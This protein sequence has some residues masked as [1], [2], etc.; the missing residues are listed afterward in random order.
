MTIEQGRKNGEQSSKKLFPVAHVDTSKLK[1]R[2]DD[3]PANLIQSHSE[4]QWQ[5][6]AHST[7][8]LAKDF[9]KFS[10]LLDAKI[11]AK[12]GGP[13]I[14]ESS[15]GQESDEEDVDDEGADEMSE[16]DEEEDGS[17]GEMEDEEEEA[18]LFNM[19]EADLENLDEQLKALDS[20]VDEDA[21]PTK[22]TKSVKY[23]KT[24]VD[25]KFFSLRRMEADID[26]LENMALD[27]DFGLGDIDDESARERYNY[28][29]FFDDP[30]DAAPVPSEKRGKKRKN[31]ADE[32]EKP[33]K[34]K[35]VR[36]DDDQGEDEE[37]DEDVEDEA[38][39]GDE[40]IEDEENDDQP[41]LFGQ[42]STETGEEETGLAQRMKKIKARIEKLETENLAPRSWELQGE[43]A[44]KGREEDALLQQHIQ[45]E[46]TNKR[47]PEVT[48]DFDAKLAGIIRQR[49]KDN[50][51]DDPQR[52]IKKTETTEPYRNE[53]IE[54]RQQIK[55]SLAEVY[56]K[57]YQK[58]SGQVVEET[59]TDPLHE[60]ID[61]LV[62][63]LF[64]NLDALYHYEFAPPSLKPEL[65]IVSNMAALK[66]EEVG[67]MASTDEQLLAP[68]ETQKHH[69]GD[70]KADE[71]R[72]KT[73]KL[74]ARR[75]K[76]NR[77][78]VM[79]T[80]VLG[81]DGGKIGAGDAP[82]KERT[83]QKTHKAKEF[84]QQLNETVRAE[85]EKKS[86]KA[87]KIAKAKKEM[88]LS[89]VQ[90]IAS[91]SSWMSNK[92]G[93]GP[94]R[95][96]KKGV[97]FVGT[98]PAELKYHQLQDKKP[99]ENYGLQ[100]TNHQ[101]P[102]VGKIHSKL[103]TKVHMKKDKVYAWCSCGYSGTQPLCDGTHNMT[104][105]P[106]TNLKPVRFIPDRDMTVWLCNCKQTKNRP[107]CDGSHKNIK[108]DDK[109]AGLFD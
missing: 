99:G 87:D 57:E 6:I 28:K 64:L 32:V 5:A 8:Q 101:L 62:R 23:R 73:D 100:G 21:I 68:E 63:S 47:P 69:K 59:K 35:T 75:K 88:R 36:W 67:M 2:D 61:G 80:R 12:T 44:A 46:A 15:D 39:G 74:R 26:E 49:I 98:E 65:K 53:R 79:A 77:Q 10:Y 16:N 42:G 56:E 30:D 18:D 3:L 95:L 109:L 24:P 22:T 93:F 92:T 14:G 89:L 7:K 27:D 40:E 1:S 71:E 94:N 37:E 43:V 4:A 106:K 54:D 13:T 103:P 78:H 41:V 97:H 81:K 52:K 51:W 29:D 90:R 104:H 31:V 60:E 72:T 34:K 58:N 33:K 96:Y 17:E 55:Q 38:D 19:K 11:Q 82:K 86:T 85:I 20:D 45:F 108:D 83:A 91:S 105:T 84:M 107:F 70:I 66:V 25:D 50:V 9:K 76:K 102:G 48:E